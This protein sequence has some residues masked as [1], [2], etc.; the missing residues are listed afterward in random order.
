MFR[1]V[2]VFLPC[3][4]PSRSDPPPLNFTYPIYPNHF[5]RKLHIKRVDVCFASIYPICQ[6][7]CKFREVVVFLTCTSPTMAVPPPLYSTYPIYPKHFG[8][9]L[10]IKWVDVCI[11]SIYHYLPG[12]MCISEAS[13]LSTRVDVS[14]V[15]LQLLAMQFI[16]QGYAP[17]LNSTYP[18]YPKHFCRKLH[19]KW[20]DVCYESIYPYLPGQM[21]K[22]VA[23][24]ISTPRLYLG[25]CVNRVFV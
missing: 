14:L 3:S 13:T 23:S 7:R 22:S 5:G 24:T 11:A 10:H 16:D 9:K 17:P 19:R 12:Q 18:I 8:L 4:S 25:R 2:V 1:E 6:G 21:Y 20:V 15:G